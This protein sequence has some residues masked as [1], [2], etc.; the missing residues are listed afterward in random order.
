M[1]A[2]ALASATAAAPKTYV[3]DVFS[4]WLYTEGSSRQTITNNID[5]SGKGG[6]VWLKARGS[7]FN[8]ALYD[9]ARGARRR[10]QT[11][12]TSAQSADLNPYGVE[13]SSTG[14]TTDQ[15]DNGV[16]Y[17]SWTFR[18]Q[19]KFFDVVTYTG[20]AT[21][22]TI[23]HDL[24]STPGCIIIKRT[25]AGGNWFVYHRGLSNPALDFINLNTTSAAS[26]NFSAYWNSTAPTSTVFS[27]GTEADINANGG[28]YVAYLFAHDAGGFGDSGSDSVVKC[29][30]FTTDGSGVGNFVDL[31]WEPQFVLVKSS[32]TSQGWWLFDNMR[33]IASG[34]ADALLV[35]NTTA[36][37]DGGFNYLDVSATGFQLVQYGSVSA[38]YI[39]IAIRR[40]PMKT[41]TDATKV[42]SVSTVSS[43]SSPYT[44]STGFPV[45]MVWLRKTDVARQTNS[46]DRLRGSST[47]LLNQLSLGLTD[48]EYTASSLGLGFDNN[49]A[50]VDKGVTAGTGG[51]P[52]WLAFR[53]APGFCDVVGYAGNSTA[54][55]IGHN[56]GVAPELLI[57]K[58]R[59]ST[60]GWITW[61]SSLSLTENLTLN[62]N[63]AK[64]TGNNFFNST[65]PSTSVITLS[66]SGAVNQSSV[67]YIAYLFATCPG[68]SKCFN[69]TGTGTTLQINCG[70]TSGA[71]FVMIKRTDS[72]GDWYVWD[73]ARGII[74]GNDSYLLLNST[75]AEVTNTDYIDPYSAG[76][77]ISSTAPAAINANGGSFIYLAI[78]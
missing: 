47:N 2:K 31:G 24:G 68:V 76:F 60:S 39:Y 41:P 38:D 64:N 72:T 69:Y 37:E 20:N 51:Q 17:A 67:N 73:S 4:T 59:N 48:A 74:S 22:R 32:S 52:W 78:A 5:L 43:P 27:L 10:L 56:L 29:G 19:A 49:T 11:D 21:N 18:E 15:G 63:A 58:A 46:I 6:L 23:A 66:D 45:D 75:A 25:N 36:A 12:G 62:S 55:T 14:F 16:T 7:A 42:F 9:T 28:T 13:F 54:R 70:F 50:F 3:E 53:R 40:G 1:L 57:F 44:V 26:T 33:G 8:H 65:A 71:R 34:G 61:S 77:E 30:S 35:A